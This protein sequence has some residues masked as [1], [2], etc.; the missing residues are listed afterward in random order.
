ML[1]RGIAQTIQICH[2]ND[3]RRLETRVFKGLPARQSIASDGE[4]VLGWR[5]AAMTQ[6]GIS[7]RVWSE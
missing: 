7:F 5:G 2:L 4:R 1:R 6:S 3:T